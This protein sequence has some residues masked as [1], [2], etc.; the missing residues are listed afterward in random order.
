MK[1][2]MRHP[3]TLLSFFSASVSYRLGMRVTEMETLRSALCGQS[4]YYLC[5]RCRAAL[6]RDF[7]SYCD[8]CG[9]RLDWS[10]CEVE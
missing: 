2:K 10:K 7:Q 8:H 1:H 5:P 6:E 9:Q 4:E 3:A